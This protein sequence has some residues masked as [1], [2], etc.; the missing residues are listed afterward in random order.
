MRSRWWIC[1]F[2]VWI[3]AQPCQAES[4]A[5]L[6]RK[7]EAALAAHDAATAMK[8]FDAALEIDPK[9]GVA[10]FERAKMLLK[11]DEAKGAISDFTVAI[12]SDSKNAAAFDGRGEA[13]MKLKQPD[14]KGAF[15]DFQ[16]AIDAAPD[17]PEPLL[18]RASYLVQIGDLSAARLDLEKARPLADGQT[19]DAIT[20]ML[21]RLN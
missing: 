13:K 3:L 5:D 17:K 14:A 12:V 1:G 20:K 6:V 15:E 8:N 4:A 18:I 10:S 9:N 7:G 19:A 16:Q 11:L 21:G 2:L